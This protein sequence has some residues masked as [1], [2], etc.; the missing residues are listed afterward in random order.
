MDAA[1]RPEEWHDF[2]VMVGGAGA[3]L[4]GLI[5]VA[6]SL[7]LRAVLRNP[8]HRGRAGSSL[9]ALMSAVLISAAVLIPGQ[10]LSAL[11]VEVAVLALAS[12]AYSARGM[13][14]LPR[15]HRIGPTVELAVGMVGATLAVLAGLSLIA[16]AGGGLLLLL[17]GTAIALGSSVWNAW[18]LMVDVASE[19]AAQ[20]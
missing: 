4:T 19:D 1:Y 8:W 20:P 2:Y 9:I 15:S 7:H 6:V 13:L 3:V 17:P 11:G 12:P 5:F 18:R 10:P 16:Q 14:H